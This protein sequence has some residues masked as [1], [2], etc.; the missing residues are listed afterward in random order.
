VGSIDRA[1][2]SVQSQD[3]PDIEHIVVDGGSTD[4]TL[5]KLK[6][7]L[8]RDAV[9]LSEPDRGMYDAINKGLRLATGDVI[10]L[11]HSDDYFESNRIL[12]G[13]VA[14]FLDSSIDA[15]YGD[16]A[17]FS[18]EAPDRIVRRYSSAKFKPSRLGWGWMPAHTTLFI[19]R[20]N[21]LRI[22][23]YKLDYTIAA[24]FDFVC[25]AFVLNQIRYSYI[26]KVL[27]KM[28]TGG[29]SSAGLRNTLNLNKE[30][31]RACRK[32]GIHTNWLKILS[33]YPLKALEYM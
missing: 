17:F 11:L 19:R 14:K 16:A 4:G 15:V 13:V 20:E 32:N 30:V 6:T 24:D 18:S 27:V 9:L 5:Q 12:S 28:Q 25:R 8:G 2:R 22:G 31:M 1:V 10:G 23:E 33:K 29:L 26:P 3:Y 7:C 21:Y